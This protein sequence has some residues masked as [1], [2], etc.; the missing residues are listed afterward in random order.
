MDGGKRLSLKWQRREA[1]YLISAAQAAEVRRYCRDYLPA[2]RFADSREGNEYPILSAYLDSPARRL[3]ADTLD[4]RSKRY[5]LRVRTYRWYDEPA[6]DLPTFFEIK[7]KIGGT[8]HKTR[9]RVAARV[10]HSLLWESGD[11]L[12]EDVD[13]DEATRRN[14][15]EFLQRRAWIGAAPVIGIA[16]RREAYEGQGPTGVRIT[17]DRD[18]HYGT[19]DGAPDPGTQMWWPCDAGGVILEVKFTS[20]YPEWVMHMLRR[21][22]VQRRGVCKYVICCRAAGIDSRTVL[23]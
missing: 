15:D 10:G 3:L 14:V 4:K 12:P 6:A 13:C 16:Y 11:L 18:L 17:L 21:L 9:A 23:A 5:K 1:K 2:D 7:Q 19:Y 8:V 20:T 22:E